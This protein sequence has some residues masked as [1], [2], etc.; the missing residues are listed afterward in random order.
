MWADM[1]IRVVVAILPTQ[2]SESDR[3]RPP[4]AIPLSEGKYTLLP[5]SAGV[6]VGTALMSRVRW[7]SASHNITPPPD[8]PHATVFRTNGN[9][10][11][12]PRRLGLILA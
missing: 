9:A 5:S 6:A 4:P 11:I 12:C 3:G 10:N 8:L 7:G 2:H 1:F